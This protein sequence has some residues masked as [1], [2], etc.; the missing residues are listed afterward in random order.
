[1][2]ISL[3][4]LKVF[5]DIDVRPR[6]LA[7]DLS[8]VGIVAEG[9]EQAGSDTILDFDIASNR[10]DCLSHFGV[11]REVA[12]RYQKPLRPVA[13]SVQESAEAAASQVS[14]TIESPQLCARYCARVI[15]NVKVGPSPAWFAQRLQSLW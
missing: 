4:W 3:L 9:L 12:T 1:M 2:K 5:V 7:D 15:R 8:M 14:V 13:V 10:P 6:Q 11:A